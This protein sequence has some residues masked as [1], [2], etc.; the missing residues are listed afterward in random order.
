MLPIYFLV[1]GF[2][3]AITYFLYAI[4]SNLCVIAEHFDKHDH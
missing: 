4:A 1:T 2:I 3:V